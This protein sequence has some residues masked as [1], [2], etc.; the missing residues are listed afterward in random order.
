MLT[1][2]GKNSTIAK[3][4]S[5]CLPTRKRCASHHQAMNSV[6]DGFEDQLMI[7]ALLKDAHDETPSAPM[8]GRC[9]QSEDL[10]A[11][12]SVYRLSRACSNALSATPTVLSVRGKHSTRCQKICRSRAEITHRFDSVQ[13]Q[14]EATKMMMLD[15]LDHLGVWVE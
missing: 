15:Q 1:C 7:L 14:Q 4:T 6:I 5:H 3:L 12:Y 2:M 10:D 13:D 8:I 9:M 11:R